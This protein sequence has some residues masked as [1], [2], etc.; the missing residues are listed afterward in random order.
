MIPILEMKVR[1]ASGLSLALWFLLSHFWVWIIF[2]PP[3]WQVPEWP[4]LLLT[5]VDLLWWKQQVGPAFISQS[6]HGG[7]VRM[8]CTPHVL[9][10]TML[11]NEWSKIPPRSGKN[12]GCFRRMHIC[13]WILGYINRGHAE[14][15]MLPGI[16]NTDFSQAC[17]GKHVAAQ[18]EWF[19]LYK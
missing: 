6:W 10:D 9:V 11:L 14:K 1:A 17:S 7:F 16:W 4:S 13:Y 19:R 5:S 3:H 2:C 12:Q 8:V 15:G 18:V